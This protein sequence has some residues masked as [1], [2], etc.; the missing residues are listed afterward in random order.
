MNTVAQTKD[1]IKGGTPRLKEA[2]LPASRDAESVGHA[3]SA[4]VGLLS[5][6]AEKGGK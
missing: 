4:A 2:P 5:I 1:V 6:A 3:L